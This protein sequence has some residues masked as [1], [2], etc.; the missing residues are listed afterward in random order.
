MCSRD[1][2]R[3]GHCGKITLKSD[4]E[5]AIMDVLKEIANLHGAR[6]TLLEHSP[7]AD[8]QLNGFIER[9]IRS[10]EEM[11]RV[12]LF[13]LSS[14]VGSPV[15]VHSPV[16]PWIAEHATDIPNERH[17]ASDGKSAYERL[18]R[19]QHRGVLLPL[20][21]A[22]MFRVAGKV[23]GGVMTERWHLGTWLGKRFHTEEHIV[24]RNGDGLVIRS[25]AVK[26]MPA[27]TTLEDLHTIKGSPLASSGVLRS[28]LLD[29]PRPILS[30]DEPPFFLVEERPVPRNMKIFARHSQE[31]RVH[32]RLCKMQETVAQKYS[33]PGLAHSQDCRTRIE[34]VS[35]TDPVY[36][37]RAERAEQRKKD[38]YAVPSGVTPSSSASIPISPGASSSSGVKAYIE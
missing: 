14:R 6:G 21:A 38:F 13:Y 19:R 22:V 25:R 4:Q 20:G 36:R 9:G 16:F 30:G 7:V 32:A 23:R 31:V 15:S 33:H 1:L 28:V 2:E 29:V 5:P 27:E 11:T 12:L 26:A 24:A 34:A 18:K 17:V 10:V 35:R 3:L 37:D 8:S